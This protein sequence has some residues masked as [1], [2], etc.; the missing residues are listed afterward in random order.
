MEAARRRVVG[1]DLPSMIGDGDGR[2]EEDCGSTW[3]VVIYVRK[4]VTVILKELQLHVPTW[5]DI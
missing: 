3:Q 5:I 4:S 1:L 2:G